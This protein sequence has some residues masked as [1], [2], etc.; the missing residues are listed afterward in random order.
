MIEDVEDICVRLLRQVA[1]LYWSEE[2]RLFWKK[3]KCF[4]FIETVLDSFTES[5]THNTPHD[6]MSFI[7]C[8][9]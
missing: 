6:S 5:I 3:D 4:L 7:N 8:N 2:E 9:A 1:V